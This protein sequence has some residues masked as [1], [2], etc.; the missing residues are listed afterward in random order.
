MPNVT[1]YRRPT[2][3]EWVSKLGYLNPTEYYPLV[4]S[5]VCSI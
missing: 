5:K 2:L 3:E 4:I 1:G